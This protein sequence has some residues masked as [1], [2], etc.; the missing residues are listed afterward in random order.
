M[1][2]AFAQMEG[3]VL[4]CFDFFERNHTYTKGVVISRGKLWRWKIR[5]HVLVLSCHG[6]IR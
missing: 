4:F 3:F 5:L 6:I 1:L 2:A